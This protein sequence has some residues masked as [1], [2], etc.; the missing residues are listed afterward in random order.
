MYAAD[1]EAGTVVWIAR[2]V[3]DE[4][5]KVIDWLN[6][7]T[8]INFWALEVELWRIGDS[9]VAPKFNVVCEPNELFKPDGVGVQ[10]EELSAT[11][12]AQLEFWKGFAEHLESSGSSFNV[13]KPQAHNWYSLRIG[14]SRAY[15]SC[16]IL[17]SKAGRLG[18]E[19]YIPG[20][21]QADAIFTALGEDRAAIDAELSPLGTP[22]WQELPDKKACRIALYREGVD[23]DDRDQWGKASG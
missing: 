8:S 18:C 12:L 1:R 11:K 20:R 10:G 13:Q 16:T 5:R 21:M 14:R 9:P 23:F 22:D 7:E 19:L 2:Q 17:M 15:V 6:R 3:T 4:Y